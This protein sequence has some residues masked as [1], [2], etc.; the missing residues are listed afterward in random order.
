MAATSR[1]AGVTHGPYSRASRVTAPEAT[2][3]WIDI[4][5]VAVIAAS[6]ATLA[7][8]HPKY[9]VSSVGAPPTAS[10]SSP[11]NTD[12][13]MK[14]STT[15]RGPRAPTLRSAQ[16]PRRTPRVMNTVGKTAANSAATS[17]QA[18]PPGPP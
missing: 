10:T 15:S 7:S 18:R 13:R 16:R 9:Q 6:T 11:Q 3:Q 5:Q 17:P 12:A 2:A 4:F 14:A 1:Y 8:M